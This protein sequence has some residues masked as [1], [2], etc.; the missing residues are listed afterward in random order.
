[1]LCVK[2]VN[3]RPLDLNV[4]WL[5]K[6]CRV[7]SQRQLTDTSLRCVC[8]CT[9]TQVKDTSQHSECKAFE[10]LSWCCDVIHR[11][12]CTSKERKRDWLWS[13][14]WAARPPGVT[15][16]VHS[17]SSSKALP[18]SFCRDTFWSETHNDI[19]RYIIC[20]KHHKY[21]TNVT[22]HLIIN[23]HTHTS[24]CADIKSAWKKAEV[25]K[26]TCQEILFS[27]TINNRVYIPQRCV[28]VNIRLQSV[29]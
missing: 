20:C 13:G 1:M 23:A 29:L 22:A 7:T 18:H 3:N 5:W 27:L 25:D 21:T 11:S 8:V 6:C 28:E 9:Q 24:Y 19:T 16:P 10:E 12:V 4:F 14:S 26:E 17:F 2:Y 15:G